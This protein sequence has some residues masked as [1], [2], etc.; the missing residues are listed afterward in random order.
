MRGADSWVGEARQGT[1]RRRTTDS[2][3]R[4]SSVLS[5]GAVWFRKV[6]PAPDCAPGIACTLR[7]S[8]CSRPDSIG[9]QGWRSDGHGRGTR[10][11]AGCHRR[12]SARGSHLKAGVASPRWLTDPAIRDSFA[13]LQTGDH[14]RRA[15]Y[16]VQVFQQAARDSEPLDVWDVSFDSEL[17]HREPSESAKSPHLIQILR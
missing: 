15:L 4:S 16:R 17:Q 13:Q 7:R 5:P 1:G 9:A 10:Q 12:S 11:R 3:R 14:A 6:G 2:G 8:C